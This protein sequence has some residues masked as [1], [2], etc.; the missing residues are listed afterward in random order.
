[1]KLAVSNIAW[2]NSEFNKFY[3]L[4]SLLNCTGVEIA[5]S[6][7]WKKFPKIN[8]EE[9]LIFLN[10]IKKFKIVERILKSLYL[11]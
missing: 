9:K 4:I 11:I 3:E 8:K 2:K 6:K 7:L 1:M 5:P 10:D